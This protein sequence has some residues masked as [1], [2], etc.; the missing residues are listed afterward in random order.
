MFKRYKLD[1][2]TSGFYDCSYDCYFFLYLMIHLT[3]KIIMV[4]WIIR[5]K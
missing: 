2:F 4:K 1:Q 3:I 5:Y